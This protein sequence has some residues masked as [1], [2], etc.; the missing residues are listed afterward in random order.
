MKTQAKLK[1]KKSILQQALQLSKVP[2]IIACFVT[3]I[4]FILEYIGLPENVI[5]II[6]LLWL[7]LGFS[8]YWSIKWYDK[9]KFLSIL[10]LSLCIYSPISRI[11]VAIAWWI[12]VNWQLGTHYGL[13][14][15]TFD[16][17]L[18]NHVFYGALVQIIPGFII[19]AITFVIMQSRRKTKNINQQS[20]NG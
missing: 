19:G 5:F 8:V 4:R 11:P 15:N 3:P 12:D 1:S 2:I 20:C 7:T 13:Y 14:F 18:L 6:G 9:P 17:V 10:L 16:Q